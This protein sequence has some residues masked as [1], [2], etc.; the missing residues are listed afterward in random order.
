MLRFLLDPI[1]VDSSGQSANTAIRIWNRLVTNQP[2]E[3]GIRLATASHPPRIGAM[4]ILTGLLL[5]I[6]GW[7]STNMFWRFAKSPASSV[8][9]ADVLDANSLSA[10]VPSLLGSSS[11]SVARRIHSAHTQ[12]Y[13][14]V[15]LLMILQ[16][17]F[18]LLSI[19]RS[20]VNGTN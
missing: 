17:L 7:C 19:T 6:G 18:S 1:R 11:F 9:L 3:R 12:R 20:S 14:N 4:A 5:V 2:H 10:K 16:I 15:F 13:M 8:M